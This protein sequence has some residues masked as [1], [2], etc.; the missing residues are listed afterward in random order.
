MRV[1]CIVASPFTKATA[2]RGPIYGTPQGQ[3]VP[4]DH[5]SVLKLIEWRHGL[6]PMTERDASSDVGN[7]LDVFDFA[8]ADATVPSL[9]LPPPPATACAVTDPS[10]VPTSAPLRDNAW[11]DLAKSGLLRPWGIR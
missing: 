7:I 8:N 9:P 4:F 3:S 6:D 5:A 1:P 10:A 2:T 11:L